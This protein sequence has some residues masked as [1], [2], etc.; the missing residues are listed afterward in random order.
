MCP[1]GE[2]A[3]LDL[4]LAYVKMAQPVPCLF[5]WVV[6][7]SHPALAGPGLSEEPRTEAA[8]QRAQ[9]GSSSSAGKLMHVDRQHRPWQRVQDEDEF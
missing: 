9:S 6:G 1:T 3:G 5:I 8:R 7:I 2:D 4:T